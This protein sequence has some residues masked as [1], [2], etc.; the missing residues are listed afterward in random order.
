MFVV[1]ARH[2]TT[3]FNIEDRFQGLSDS[4]LVPRGVSQAKRLNK[5]LIKNFK[6][7]VFYTS[8]LPR[9][10]E[11]YGYASVGISARH[12]ISNH[13]IEICYGSWES[14]KRAEI[15]EKLLE[16]RSLDRYNFT[17]P[18]E[19]KGFKGQSYA[20]IYPRVHE[21]LEG[22]VHKQSNTDNDICVITHHGVLIN[23]VRFFCDKSSQ[24]LNSL[25]IPNDQLIVVEIA[26]EY[27]NFRFECF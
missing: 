18:G 12:V 4:P 26:E 7:G 1:F 15:D 9:V 6:L 14:K 2:G 16:A 10:L 23:V 20:E 24:D 21:F 13:L 19:Y 11:T 17:H 5:F 22:I 8:P 3:V 25:R 27:K